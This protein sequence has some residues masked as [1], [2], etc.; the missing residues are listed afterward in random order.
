MRH[1]YTGIIERDLE[2]GWLVGEVVELPGCHSEAPDLDSL[3]ANLEEA[4]GVYL[5]GADADDLTPTSQ[6]VGTLRLE[7][8]TPISLSA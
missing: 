8:Q 7:I 5:E 1:A 4:I 6:F 3:K 2:T